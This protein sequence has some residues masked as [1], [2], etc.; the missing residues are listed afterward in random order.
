VRLSVVDVQ[1]RE[2]AVLVDGV[3]RPGVYQATWSGRTE[4]GAAPVGLYFVR[5]QTPNGNLMRRVVLA[6]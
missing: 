3:Q 4:R 5:Y 2:V 1:G 6:H